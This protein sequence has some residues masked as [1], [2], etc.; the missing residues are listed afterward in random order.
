MFSTRGG[1]GGGGRE[2]G[3]LSI[4]STV[5]GYHEHSTRCSVHWGDIMINVGKVIGKQLN[6][7]ENPNVLN[8][9]SVLMIS[10]LHS[11]ISPGN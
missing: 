9:P 6:L 8:I 1:G 4:L 7:Y 5:G 11:V 3:T 10:P 2:G